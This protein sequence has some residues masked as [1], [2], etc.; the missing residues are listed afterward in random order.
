MTGTISRAT[1]F[2][3]L[4]VVLLLTGCGHL[5]SGD[6]LTRS[7]VASDDVTLRALLAFSRQQTEATNEHRADTIRAL[8]AEPVTPV[9]LMK[10]AVIHGQNRDDANPAKAAALLEK[11]IADP[12]P[13]AS[14]LHPL[15]RI[16][17]SQYLAR[18]RLQGQN[19]RLLSEHRAAQAQVDALQDKLDA[20]TDIERSLRTPTR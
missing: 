12:S 6:G 17:H 14:T 18:V 19:E 10:L 3:V 9:T 4:V 5:S 16:L 15:A 7:E 20:L 2:I 8:E 1:L 13:E 11:V